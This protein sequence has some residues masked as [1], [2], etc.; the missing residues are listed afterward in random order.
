MIDQTISDKERFSVAL[1][2]AALDHHEAYWA[3]GSHEELTCA[4]CHLVVDVSLTTGIL[5]SRLKAEIA[6]EE[7]LPVADYEGRKS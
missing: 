4:L 6:N 2:R 5:I 1:L 7:R 3:K